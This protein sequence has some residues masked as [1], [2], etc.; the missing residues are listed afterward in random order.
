MSDMLQPGI[1]P[2]VDPRALRICN[3]AGLW[4]ANKQLA[5]L[6]ELRSGL[7]IS[8]REL[9][10]E[11]KKAEIVNKA[12]M[13]ARFT[14]ATADAFI[15]MTSALA[16]VVLPKVA[17]D[18]I[19]RVGTA[20]GAATPWAEALGNKMAGAKVDWT[21][22]AASSAREGA[23]LMT[24]NDGY[25]LLIQSSAVKVEIVNAAMQKDQAKVIRSSAFYL[26]DL[27][28]SMAKIAGRRKSEA[29][30][31]LAKSTYEYNDKIGDAF[32]ALIDDDLAT[33]MQ[34]DA[35]KA[36]L[37]R[38]GR[39]LSKKIAEL[40]GFVADCQQELGTGQQGAIPVS[41]LR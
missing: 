32:N 18:G 10:G 19:D 7:D 11:R 24:G 35:S 38:A 3:A 16:K 31:K 2:I 30:L 12:L 33:A 27:H 20:Y 13:V 14:R 15:S 4:K 17:A 36:T 8:L 34:F 41:P 39:E 29:L 6:R 21:D 25:E 5:S 23:S 40:E 22:T 9:E 26:V 28:A 37:L 1:R